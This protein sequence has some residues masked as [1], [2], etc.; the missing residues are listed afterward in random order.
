[1]PNGKGA[2]QRQDDADDP[3]RPA[4]ARDVKVLIVDDHRTFAEALALVLE[5][6]PG[7]RCTGL[8]TAVDDALDH[9]RQV[10]C[11]VVVM[12]VALPGED[13][14]Q[15]TQRMRAAHPRTRVIILTDRVEAAVLAAAVDAG[16]AAFLPKA[17]PLVDVVDAILAPPDR[18]LIIG[19]QTPLHVISDAM[20]GRERRARDQAGAGMLTRR[21][22]EV[23]ER[24]AGG[25]SAA[26]VAEELGI[27][28][29]TCRGHIKSVLSKLQAHSQLEAVVTAWQ[30]GLIHPP[31]QRPPQR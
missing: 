7:I 17:G 12:D 29:H 24:L 25:L 28:L 26:A 16:A 11:D 1:M 15:G 14:I 18:S 22:V 9:L 5:S 30:L 3:V 31:G 21:E 23:L 8:V 20:G 27:S 10:R 2:L 13:G 19:A 6:Q 4:A